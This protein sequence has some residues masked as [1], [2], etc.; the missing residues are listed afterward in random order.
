MRTSVE[1][2]VAGHNHEDIVKK[3]QELVSK[4]TGIDDHEEAMKKVDA[5][6][7][8]EQRGDTYEAKVY[9]RLR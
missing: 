6:I 2:Q 9:V 8:A 1:F 7:H 3:T 5:E 4:Y